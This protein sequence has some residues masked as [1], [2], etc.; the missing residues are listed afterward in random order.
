M[1][2]GA[3]DPIGFMKAFRN[4]ILTSLKAVKMEHPRVVVFG[5]CVH[6]LWAQ[7]KPDVAVQM[8]ELGNQLIASYDVDILCGYYLDGMADP[9]NYQ[10]FQ[11]ICAEHSAVYSY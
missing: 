5:E 11:R 9:M 6:F 3:F 1:V 4:L 2:N 8:E 10:I 7:R